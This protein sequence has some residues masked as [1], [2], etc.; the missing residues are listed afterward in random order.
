MY[1]KLVDQAVNIGC[2]LGGGKLEYETPEDEQLRAEAEW[3][4]VKHK[5]EV[6]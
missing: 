2:F 3:Q 1:R 5:Y 6:E 4:R